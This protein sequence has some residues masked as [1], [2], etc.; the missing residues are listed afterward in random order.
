MVAAVATEEPEVAANSAEVPILACKRPPGSQ[1][2]HLFKALYVFSAIP[3]RRNTFAA[4][5]S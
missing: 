5:V 2:S 4:Q 1:E 3:A